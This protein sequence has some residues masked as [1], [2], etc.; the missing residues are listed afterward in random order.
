ML[1]CEVLAEWPA[2]ARVFIERRMGCVGC[3]FAAFE[4]VTEAAA[5]YGIDCSDLASSLAVSASAQGDVNASDVS[6]R[7]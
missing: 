1:V 2:T 5:A 3:E 7:H 4:T 6:P